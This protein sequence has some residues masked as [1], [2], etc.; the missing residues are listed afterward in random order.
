[1]G[2]GGWTINFTWLSG[3]LAIHAVFLLLFACSTP[4]EESDNQPSAGGS[5]SDDDDTSGGEDGGAR[6]VGVLLDAY[7]QSLPDP[8]IQFCGPLP[9]YAGEGAD[10][11]R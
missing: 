10:G 11:P 6:I 1:M 5:P 7:D 4:V 8:N 2:Q 9:G 3:R